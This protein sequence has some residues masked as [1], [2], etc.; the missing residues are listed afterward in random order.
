MFSVV[1]HLSV[2]SAVVLWDVGSKSPG[3]GEGVKPL[4]S[5]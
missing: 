3:L 4:M 2:D 1:F 5:F